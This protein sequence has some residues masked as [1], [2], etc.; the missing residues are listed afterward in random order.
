MEPVAAGTTR[1]VMG[2]LKVIASR[3]E[4]RGHVVQARANGRVL[5][6][7]TTDSAG[8]FLLRWD[9]AAE[10][11]TAI[12]L[13]GAGGS[14]V[15]TIELTA[16]D[17]LSPPVVGFLGKDVVGFGVAEVEDDSGVAF[18]ADGDYPLC[19]TSSC[20]QVTLSWIAPSS[21]TV[22][23]VSDGD[24]V[25]EGLPA[26]G[27]LRVFARD[28]KKYTRRAW[29]PGDPKGRFSDLTLEVRRYPVLSLVVEGAAL[30]SGSEVELGASI[31]CPAGSSGLLVSV[32]TSDMEM[33]PPS[34]IW[35]PA[36]SSWGT[37]R[38]RIGSKAGRVKMTAVAPG[39]TRDGVTMDVG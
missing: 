13:F 10:E 5:D 38:A 24:V 7:S 30:R 32:M 31:S 23:V 29:L 4:L 39:Y 22:S 8:R 1:H 18:E 34:E 12:E 36:G 35:I 28:S 27:T 33:V 37:T 26:Q 17:L 6:S 19:V 25:G 14:V 16:A 20:Q 21:S 11:K 9:A 15:E 3:K 2:R